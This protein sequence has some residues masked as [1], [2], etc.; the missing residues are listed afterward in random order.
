MSLLKRFIPTIAAER[1][2]VGHDHKF[3]LLEARRGRGKSYWLTYWVRWC[4]MNRVPVRMNFAIDHYRL[5][6]QCTMNKGGNFW[7]WRE[8]VDKH[9][10]YLGRWDDVLTAHDEVVILDESSRLFDSRNRTQVK[11]V[12]YEWAQL[13]RHLRLTLVFASQSFD[14]LD[15]R[16][17]QLADNIWLVRKVMNKQRTLPQEFWAY[18]FDPF[19]Q[20]LTSAVDR[21]TAMD[22]RM[23]I[24]FAVDIATLYDTHQG[25]RLIEGEPSFTSVGQVFDH[26]VAQGVIVPKEFVAE[27]LQGVSRREARL[28]PFEAE[29]QPAALPAGAGDSEEGRQLVADLGGVWSSGGHVKAA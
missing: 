29:P 5:A 4:A 22:F 23:R 20:G 8:W 16:M 12:V 28:S 18:G 2:E 21:Q 27:T 6:L 1:Y 11:P 3:H 13:S 25:I 24:P 10:R 14:W 26:L 19:A 15:L 9:V 7:E 17:R